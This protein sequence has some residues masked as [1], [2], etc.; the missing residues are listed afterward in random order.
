MRLF[1]LSLV[2]SLVCCSNS[3]T[4]TKPLE[5]NEFIE[6]YCDVVTKFDITNRRLQQAFVDSIFTHHNVSSAEFEK[7]VNY[8]KQNPDRWQKIFDKIVAELEARAPQQTNQ[9]AK[10]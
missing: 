6:I 3:P 4:E 2:L 9:P 10:K 1:I 8:Y 5:D 7:T